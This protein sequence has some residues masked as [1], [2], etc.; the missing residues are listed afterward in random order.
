M[1]FYAC[2]VLIFIHDFIC[3]IFIAEKRRKVEEVPIKKV[4]DNQKIIKG[5]SG[6]EYVVSRGKKTGDFL[7]NNIVKISSNLTQPRQNLACESKEFLISALQQ[8]LDKTMAAVPF[9]MNFELTGQQAVQ[10]R[11]YMRCDYFID[12]S[13]DSVPT[14]EIVVGSKPVKTIITFKKGLHTAGNKSL[15]K[16]DFDE[17]MK[18]VK[19]GRIFM[20]LAQNLLG[21]EMSTAE[22]LHP[23]DVI[24]R[25][26]IEGGEQLIIILRMTFDKG[27]Q[28]GVV[29]PTIHIREFYHDVKNKQFKPTPRGLAFALRAFYNVVYPLTHV[30]TKMQDSLIQVKVTMDN[31]KMNALETSSELRDKQIESDGWK[32]DAENLEEY[33]TSPDELGKQEKEQL[34][35]EK[36]MVEKYQDEEQKNK[37]TENSDEEEEEEEDIDLADDE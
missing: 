16:L 17:F 32:S 7:S 15:L 33:E 37:G 11:K 22:I 6:K 18:V 28:D 14:T 8:G 25:E 27:D 2:T 1:K 19:E 9:N 29:R 31:L 12:F 20:A 26:C 23:D 36:D 30:V 21:K 13:T 3:I 5:S 24:I 10:D 35:W 34:D 4:D